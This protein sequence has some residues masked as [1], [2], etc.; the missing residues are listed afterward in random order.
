MKAKVARLKE[1]RVGQF[2]AG[3]LVDG[4]VET[5]KAIRKNPKTFAVGL[6]LTAACALAGDLAGISAHALIVG[7]S[8]TAAAAQVAQ[9]Y[10]NEYRDAEAGRSRIAGKMAWLPALVVATAIAG[11]AIA[12]EHHAGPMSVADISRSLSS[13]VVTGGDLPTASVTA[14][15]DWLEHR[16]Q[17]APTQ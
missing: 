13:G 1:S 7:A 4:P 16:R 9:V 10:K 17:P 15:Q 6:C 3:L 11:G 14:Y 5:W 12:A 2:A 8:G